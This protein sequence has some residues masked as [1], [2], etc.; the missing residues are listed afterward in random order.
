MKQFNNLPKLSVKPKF[1]YLKHSLLVIAFL[2][3]LG[4]GYILGT[5][6]TNGRQK[7]DLNQFWQVYDI[8]NRRFVG[9]VD[10]SKASEGAVAGLVQSLGDPFSMYLP[11]QARKDLDNELKGQFEGIGAELTQKDGLITIVAPLDGSPASTAG[12]KAKDIILKINDESTS[13]MIVDEAVSKIRG[14]KGTTV[15]LEVARP[16]VSD[17]IKLTITRDAIHIKSV[18]VKMLDGNIGFL[19]IRQF[20]D[21]TVE[22]VKKG[23]AELAKSQPKAV[24]IDLR[25]DPGGY[26]DAVAP[27][28]GQFIAPNVV[29]KERYK[30]GRT[31]L[32]RS[33]DVPVM[34]NTPLFILVNG[35]SASAA[36][37]LSGALQD[38][39][40][41]TLVG[42]K[43]FGKGSVQDIIPLK[44]GAALRLTIAEWLTPNDRQISKKGI[45]PDVVVE[46]DK[47]SDSDPVLAKALELANK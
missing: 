40:R 11:A 14:P 34:P 45:D 23:V 16:K 36:E 2:F 12:L 39:K 37:I 18:D 17:P 31:E 43:T 27:I 22:L 4:A 35:G 28:A 7:L 20:G 32:I 41:A 46:G 1:R 24:I 19:E 13:G 3:V 33:T 15:T 42:Q 8:I 25:N 9:S 21:D 10:Q 44:A 47:N 5:T 6:V 30:D 26:L 29:V 38:H